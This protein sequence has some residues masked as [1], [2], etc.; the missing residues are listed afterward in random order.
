VRNLAGIHFHTGAAHFHLFIAGN[1]CEPHTYIPLN[2][3]YEYLNSTLPLALFQ[4]CPQPVGCY[5]IKRG[6]LTEGKS[7]RKEP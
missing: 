7:V 3:N 6:G 5:L 1:D 2:S 4:K